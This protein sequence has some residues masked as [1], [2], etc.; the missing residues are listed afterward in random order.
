MS[1]ESYISTKSEKEYEEQ[2]R[3][4]KLYEIENSRNLEL[5]KIKI[6]YIKKKF[7]PPLL[8]KIV[9]HVTQH[10]DIWIDTIMTEQLY[11][12][13]EKKSPFK[14]ALTTLL[15]FVCIGLVPLLPYL[16]RL[17]INISFDLFYISVVISSF[18][19]FIVEACR[20][21]LIGKKWYVAGVEMFFIGFI[22]ASAAYGVGV[23]LENIVR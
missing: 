18:I 10:K 3:K 21:S 16:L 6:L 5:E 1:L 13:P 4:G 2:I 20:S 9:S 8:E 19:L 7:E 15:A 11:I 22:A 14:S 23:F 17:M 12:F